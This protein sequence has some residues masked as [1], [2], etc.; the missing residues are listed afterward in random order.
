MRTD[1][2]AIANDVV[3]MM[4]LVLAEDQGQY[5]NGG[6]LSSHLLTLSIS[7]AGIT[8]CTK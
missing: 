6:G 1:N 3:M 2:D 7:V 8:D 5:R 4:T